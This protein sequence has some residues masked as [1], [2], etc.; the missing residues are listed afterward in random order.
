MNELAA[1]TIHY[2]SQSSAWEAWGP[3]LVAAGAGILGAGLWRVATQLGKMTAVM[4]MNSDRIDR[5]EA[6]V[7]PT[8]ILQQRWA[9]LT[10]N[11]ETK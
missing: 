7:F 6:A 5:L 1:V 11:K 3:P 10:D 4:Q 9:G 2:V 8:A